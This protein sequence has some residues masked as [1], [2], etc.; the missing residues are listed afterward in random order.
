[1]IRV[2]VSAAVALV[3]A[4]ALAVGTGAS[5]RP[6]PAS[7]E[8][9]IDNPWFPLHPG[10][11]YVYRGRKDAKRARDVVTVLSRTTTID[12]VRCRAVDD[13]LYLNGKL[14]ERTTDW[15]AQ[16]RAGNVWYFGEETAELDR[17]GHVTSTE[18]TWRTGKHGARAG[19]VMPAHPRVGRGFRQEFYKGHAE[20]HFVTLSLSAPVRTPAA[21][22]RRALLTKEWTPLEP[23]T[24]D[25]KLY[26]RGVGMVE[27]KTVRGGDEHSVLVSVRGAPRSAA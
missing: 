17:R 3:V 20:D 7:F 6:N 15:Y 25:H 19:I 10:T 4:A 21:S 8:P 9:R 27:E 23:G 2:A 14:G 16:D 18:G 13:R 22:S 26:V 24:I 11:V 1:M 12:G 5:T